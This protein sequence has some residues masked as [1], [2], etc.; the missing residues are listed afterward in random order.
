MPAPT[1]PFVAHC[2]ELLEALGPMRARRMF[3]GWGLYQGDVFIAVIADDRLFLKT[4]EATRA[5]FDA[6][7]C[8]PFVFDTKEGPVTT[9]YRSPPPEALDSPA[10]MLPWARLALQAAVAARAGKKPKAAVRPR[11][12]APARRAA[13]PRPKT[14]GPAAK[15]KPKRLGG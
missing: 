15:P 11:A 12:P 1:P 2:I 10:L 7:G 13:K 5:V 9:S 6:H 3:G 4:G 14:A 8:E